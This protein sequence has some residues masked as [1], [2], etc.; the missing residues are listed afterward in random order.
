[1]HLQL[2]MSWSFL[3]CKHFMGKWE[4]SEAMLLPNLF[5]PNAKNMM[6]DVLPRHPAV[7]VHLLHLLLCVLT[8]VS[9]NPHRAEIFATI[10]A[11]S[12]PV[13]CSSC[14][15]FASPS[16]TLCS[17]WWLSHIEF[18]NLNVNDKVQALPTRA[19]LTTTIVLVCGKQKNHYFK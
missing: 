10:S 12:L 18:T 19:V 6:G 16:F 5:P 14:C 7:N 1:M 8:G 13:C 4:E 17:P 2:N 15:L 11:N 9:T 3:L